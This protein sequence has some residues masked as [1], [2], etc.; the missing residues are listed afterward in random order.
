MV[1]AGISYMFAK[2][3]AIVEAST[4]DVVDRRLYGFNGVDVA[5]SFDVYITQGA[6]ESVKAEAPAGLMDKIK[7]EVNGG[8]LHIYK[9]NISNWG[10]I[11]GHHKKVQIYV[12]AKDLNQFNLSGSGDVYF[13]DGRSTNSLKLKVSG[14][15]GMT[16]KVNVKTLNSSISG[17]GETRLSGRAGNSIVEVVGSGDY[18]AQS[19]ATGTCT[20]SV[21]GSGDADVNAS[22]KINATVRGAGDIR[23]GGSA[24]LVSS[25]KTGSGDISRF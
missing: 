17:S 14:P 19:L 4:Y 2:P 1:I 21:T 20:V 5:G 15:G 3:R 8:V 23:Y 25:N 7:T 12:T 9:N 18:T 10:D 24:K 6:T 13:K 16:G 22:D 11:F